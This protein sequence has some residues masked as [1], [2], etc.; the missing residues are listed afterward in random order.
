GG[1]TVS[2]YFPPDWD[3]RPRV[4]PWNGHITHQMWLAREKED[5]VSIIELL[6]HQITQAKQ[7]ARDADY[8]ADWRIFRMLGQVQ[9]GARVYNNLARA[10]RRGRKTVR[11]DRILEETADV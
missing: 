9:L 5:L 3:N 8:L 4:R 1:P 11:I 7:D 2:E 6:G 10:R